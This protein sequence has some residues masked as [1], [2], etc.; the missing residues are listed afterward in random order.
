MVS[1]PDVA[2][3]A[4]A[5]LRTSFDAHGIGMA[6]QCDAELN[7]ALVIEREDAQRF[8]Y[9]RLNA[10]PMAGGFFA[11]KAWELMRDPVVVREIKA[12]NGVYLSEHYPLVA[13][14][15]L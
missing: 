4:F 7:R 13:E 14:I 2:N 6:V 5:G 1:S 10:I 3:A 8:G 15:A 12:E 9:T 11:T